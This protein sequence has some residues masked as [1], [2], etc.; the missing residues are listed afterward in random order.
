MAPMMLSGV[1][2]F[3]ICECVCV[4]TDPLRTKKQQS[5][6]SVAGLTTLQTLTERKMSFYH[7]ASPEQSLRH[8]LPFSLDSIIMMMR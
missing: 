4:R 1:S 8:L 5:D 3:G 7:E 6:S 2:F